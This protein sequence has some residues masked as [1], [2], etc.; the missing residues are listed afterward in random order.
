MEKLSL[1]TFVTAGPDP[2]H[3]QY[4]VLGG[5]RHFYEDFSHNRIYPAL[6]ELIEL[7]IMLENLREQNQLFRRTGSRIREVDLENKTLVFEQTAMPDS[8]IERMFELIEWSLPHLRDAIREGS[9]MYDFVEEN[10][11][12]EGVGILPMYR[13]EGYFIIPEVKS[14]VIHVFRYELSLYSSGEEKFRTLKTRLEHSIQQGI[15][16]QAPESIKYRLVKEHEDLPNPA[17]FFC[18]TDLD[19]PFVESI[20]PVAKRKFIQNFFS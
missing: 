8:N 5:L 10:I 13:D 19:F 4:A 1:Q 14:S 6:G 18:E 9:A 12:I 17:T 20:L 15:I 7:N 16:A 11:E 2:E 3:N